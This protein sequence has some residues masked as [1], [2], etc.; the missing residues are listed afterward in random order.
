MG[1]VI[2]TGRDIGNPSGQGSTTAVS[3]GYDLVAGGRDIWDTSDQFHF[4]HLNHAGDF[5]LAARMESLSAAHLYTKSG[6]MA[7]T[8]LEPDSEFVYFMVFPDNRPRNK[9]NGGY[10]FQYREEQ[11]SDCAAIYPADYQTGP[12]EFPV[13][14]PRA[15]LRLRRTGDQF[16]AFYST[17]GEAWNVYSR[18]RVKLGRHVHLGLAVTSHDVDRTTVASFRDIALS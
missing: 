13:E 12:P 15:W 14:F 9:N 4:A 1:T 6:L 5:D 7:R 8:S 16:E 11:A 17:D 3:T 10:E 2:L 18:R